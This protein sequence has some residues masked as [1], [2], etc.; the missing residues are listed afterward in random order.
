MANKSSAAK[1]QYIGIAI[2]LV[3]NLLMVLFSEGT[4]AIWF[5]LTMLSILIGIPYLVWQLVRSN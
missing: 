1:F 2:I 5:W 3:V 4:S